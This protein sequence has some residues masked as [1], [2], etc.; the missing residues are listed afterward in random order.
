MISRLKYDELSVA[1]VLG[2]RVSDC[3]RFKFEFITGSINL[4]LL[5]FL[6]THCFLNFSRIANDPKTTVAHSNMPGQRS[7]DST[8]ITN[9]SASKIAAF[10]HL[11]QSEEWERE[12]TLHRL[13]QPWNIASLL[14]ALQLQQMWCALLGLVRKE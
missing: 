6:E 7:R 5:L 12:E 13:I 4:H 1:N 9:Y 10:Q 2:A 8:K 3:C 14:N 11:L